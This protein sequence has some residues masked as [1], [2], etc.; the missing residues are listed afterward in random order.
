MDRRATTVTTTTTKVA[1]TTREAAEATGLSERQ[2]K[3]AMNAVEADKAGM[4]IL[5]AKRVGARSVLIRADDLAAWIES[6]ADY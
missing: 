5:P 2:I 4:P 3:R 6:L 1:Y